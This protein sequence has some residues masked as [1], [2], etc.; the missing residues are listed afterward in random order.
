[1]TIKYLKDVSTIPAVVF[2]VR[3]VDLDHANYAR[4]NMHRTCIS[5]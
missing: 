4:H 5:K 3:E 2:A 1:M